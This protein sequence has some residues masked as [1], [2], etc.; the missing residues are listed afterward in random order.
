MDG[1]RRI[2]QQ[3]VGLRHR[4]GV[5]TAGTDRAAAGEALH[6]VLRPLQRAV[7]DA[8]IPRLH[9]QQRADDAARRAARAEYQDV[10]VFELQ[11]EIDHEVAQQ[12]DAVRVVAVDFVVAKR[13]R[14]HGAGRA[15]ALAEVVHEP[16]DGALVGNG[17]IEAF[18]ARALKLANGLLEFVGRNTQ[19]LVLQFLP[20]LLREQPVDDGRTAVC[21]RIAHDTI[22]VNGH[23]VRYPGW[24]SSRQYTYS[25][26][27]RAASSAK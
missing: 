3:V 19:Q 8:E 6:E 17:D 14:I 26:S 7:G 22:A 23:R 27:Q 18:A 2:D 4:D 11:P 16:E 25:T 13:Q 21:Y 1:R 5:E 12:A 15:G 9:F 24:L 10:G 20:G